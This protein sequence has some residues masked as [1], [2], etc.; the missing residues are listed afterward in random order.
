MIKY[1]SFPKQCDPI[2][3]SECCKFMFEK[4]IAVDVTG[5]GSK[6][7]YDFCLTTV[8]DALNQMTEKEILNSIKDN[9]CVGEKTI[10]KTILHHFNTWYGFLAS[11]VTLVCFWIGGWQIWHWWF[12][13][14]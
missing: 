4:G 5:M 6:Y 8:G 10:L 7:A 14:L 1:K 13:G 3:A 12:F 2:A 9:Y 11:T